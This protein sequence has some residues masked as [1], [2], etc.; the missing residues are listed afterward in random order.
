ML[1]LFVPGAV[2]W[3]TVRSA[4]IQRGV[5]RLQ[6]IPPHLRHQLAQEAARF[7]LSVYAVGAETVEV[8]IAES[9][10]GGAVGHYGPRKRGVR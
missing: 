5:W 7:G 6:H 2:D 9:V 1:G 3:P 10:R 4:V 8:R